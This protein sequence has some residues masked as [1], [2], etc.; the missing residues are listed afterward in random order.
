MQLKYKPNPAEDFE[1]QMN[2]ILN[3]ILYTTSKHVRNNLPRDNR[4]LALVASK[5]K[6]K[7]HNICQIVACLGQQNVTVQRE[8]GVSTKQRIPYNYGMIK[9]GYDGRSLPHFH[10]H[11]DSPAARGFCEN[12]FIS[13]LNPTEFFFHNTSG[14]EGLTDTAIKTSETGYLQRKLMKSMEDLLIFFDSTVRGANRNI[15]QFVYG[16]DS[17][18]PTKLEKLY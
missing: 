7:S 3:N 12:S 8:D 1:L 5:S 9:G 6:G 14:R 15:I 11:D 17:M 4:I 13:G 10:R 16:D 2:N 18:D